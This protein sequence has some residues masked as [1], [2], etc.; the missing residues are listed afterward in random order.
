VESGVIEGTGTV[1]VTADMCLIRKHT[2][3]LKFDQSYTLHRWL[4]A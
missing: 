1:D 2:N 4:A 3:L